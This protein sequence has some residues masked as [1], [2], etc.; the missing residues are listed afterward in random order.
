MLDKKLV[1]QLLCVVSCGADA[2]RPRSPTG[3]ATENAPEDRQRG[4]SVPRSPLAGP[5]IELGHPPHDETAL[6]PASPGADTSLCLSW[7]PTIAVDPNDPRVVAVAQGGTAKVSLDGGGTFDV[8]LNVAVPAGYNL[9]GDPSVAFDSQGNL[10][11]SYLCD[12][13]VGAGRDVCIT[14]YACDA[15]AGTCNLLAGIAWPVNATLDA[16]HGP[17]Q[18]ADKNWLA[19]DAT[20]ASGFANGLYLVWTD[21]EGATGWEVW[22]TASSNNGQDWSA[23]QQLSG[24]DEHKAWPAHVAVA[25]NGFVY[26]AYHSQTGFLDAAD[27]DEPKRVPDGVSGL[28]ALRR[29]EDGGDSFEPSTFPYEAGEADMT[30]NVQHKA[31]GVIPGARYW[32]QGSS[33][34][35]ILPDPVDGRVHV[36]ANDD[37]DDNVDDGDAADVFMATSDDHGDSWGAPARVDTGPAGTFQVMPTA[38]IDALTGTIVVAYYDNRSL[39][40]NG[41]GNFLLDLLATYSFDGGLSWLPEVDFNDGSFDPDVSTSCRLCCDASEDCFGQPMTFRIGEY[42]GVAAADC[43]AHAAWADGATCNGE[44]DTFYDRDP[45]LDLEVPDVAAPAPLVL[46]CNT[47]GGVSR[48]DPQVQAWLASAFAQDNCGEVTISDDAPELFPAGCAPGGAVTGVTFTAADPCGNE[49]S[50]ESTVTVVDSTPP[51]VSCSAAVDTLW[52]PNH[53]LVDVGLSFAV[54]EV[55][56]ATP[57]TEVGATTD[58]ATE[59]TLGAGDGKCPDAVIGGG[60][61]LELRAERSGLADGR[62]YVSTVSA[63][64]FC[65]QVDACDVQVAVPKSMGSGPATD[66][67]QA[68]D[69]AACQ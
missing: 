6:A 55:C 47:A 41:S 52:P 37:P 9:D 20:P 65:G 49:A 69:A 16:G 4:G 24:D 1:I 31:N 64:D 51:E 12:L 14:G 48:D 17:P 60:G 25:P 19:S 67:G 38:A 43:T 10:F 27:A 33:Q 44:T 15:D 21:L 36:V 68:F 7:E 53:D 54:E 23:A 57:A 34:P 8:T 2:T 26:V 42:N 13:N 45:C 40:V 28:I 66:S 62:V 63:T 3:H 5:E 22:F 32:L 35:W 61:S 59:S 39:A 58:E 30:W 46:E 11:F 29:S 50:D 56:D 18:N